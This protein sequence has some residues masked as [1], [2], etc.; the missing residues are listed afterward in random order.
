MTSEQVTQELWQSIRALW[1]TPRISIP[2]A[3]T[4]AL[5]IGVLTAIFSV[6]DA[7]LF[8]PLPFPS[9]ERLVEVVALYP[10]GA[11]TP[12]VPVD[13]GRALAEDDLP[14]EEGLYGV[15]YL[16]RTDGAESRTVRAYGATPG[17]LGVL[18][19]SPVLGRSF[20][21]G[22]AAE[23]PVLLTYEYWRA[24]F[25]AD[26]EVLGRTLRLD[27]RL[28]TVVG[29]L[30]AGFGRFPHISGGSDLWLPMAL[31]GTVAGEAPDSVFFLARL[32]DELS[33]TAYAER[34]TARE[35][36]LRQRATIDDQLRLRTQPLGTWRTTEQG[37]S[38]TLIVLGA[39]VVLLLV[40]L[41]NAANFLL[42]HVQVRSADRAIRAALGASGRRLAR[43]AFLQ[44]LV[45]G[46]A[47]GSAALLVVSA[48]VP[49]VRRVLPAFME[50]F[51]VHAVAVGPRVLLFAVAAT[52]LVALALAGWHAGAQARWSRAV[53]L[54]PGMRASSRNARWR[55]VLVGLQLAVS[56][57]LLVGAG[58]LIRSMAEIVR[59]DLGFAQEN[60]WVLHVEAG[61]V[62]DEGTVAAVRLQSAERLR[63]AVADL[64]GVRAASLANGAPPQSRLVFP[65][66]LQ[67]DDG[68]SPAGQPP[69]LPHIAADASLL[70]VLGVP[71]IQ[72]RALGPADR[73]SGNVV[74]DRDLAEFLWSGEP[75]IGRRFRTEAEGTWLTVVGVVGELKLRGW[76]ERSS[77]FALIRPLDAEALADEITLILHADAA[78]AVNA[79][80]IVGLVRQF[81]PENPVRELVPLAVAMA[82]TSEQPRF[83]LI[84][85]LVLSG[86][87]LALA[88][89]GLYALVANAVQLRQQEFAV[90]M[91]VGATGAS[92]RRLVL[93]ETLRLSA[94]GL[95]AGAG[96]G[97][98]A[99]GVL[100]GLLVG[101]APGDPATFAGVA[102]LVL[103]TAIAASLIPAVRASR[104]DPAFLLRA[105]P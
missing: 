34:I 4:L 75:P 1:K 67:R 20:V 31:D 13:V 10:S 15:R 89:F 52:I 22:D 25:G 50:R 103:V 43:E 21:S 97:W 80:A 86:T 5:G 57:A 3:T 72:G 29:V 17:L 83:V 79:R 32:P 54:Q 7:V 66:E 56:A 93:G 33:V 82:R 11:W 26:P 6:A 94:V 58:L 49:L 101:V 74:I 38:A 76:D 85:M 59:V 16:V 88:A 90:R 78:G 68:V 81:F 14:G 27:G 23:D 71:V 46:L 36:A 70:S 39:G 35:T 24:A 53:V 62:P 28:H 91:A 44:T 100:R 105:Q 69:F 18:A 42:L 87:A 65:L 19:V 55:T 61:D 12:D 84:L 77:R 47:A 99:G 30:P 51:S 98:W 64:P 48:S 45:V 63:D 8:R 9:P 40:A 104:S 73:G 96:A 92:L 60:R 102:L 95:A 37:E 2:I 41:L